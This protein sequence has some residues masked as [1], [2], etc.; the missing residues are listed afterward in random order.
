MNNLDGVSLQGLS[1]TFGNRR[2]VM[3]NLT[4]DA[5]IIVIQIWNHLVQ[6]D[7]PLFDSTQHYARDSGDNGC[8]N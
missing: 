8:F 7:L 1:D 3:V 2:V 6:D 4:V 5:C